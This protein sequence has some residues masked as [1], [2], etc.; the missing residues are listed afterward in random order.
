MGVQHEVLAAV[1]EC[2]RNAHR[3]APAEIVVPL[4]AQTAY[5]HMLAWS[6][7]LYKFMVAASFM[8][9]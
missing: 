3:W 6:F 5:S 2:T 1:R 8:F 4:E 7:V 9:L